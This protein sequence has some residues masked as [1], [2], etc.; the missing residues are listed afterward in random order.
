MGAGVPCARWGEAPAPGH[1]R[2]GERVLFSGRLGSQHVRVWLE[3]RP[4]GIALLSHDI[5]PALER[6]FGKDEIETFLEVDAADFSALAAA[7]GARSGDPMALLTSRFRGNS[8][9]TSELRR[10]I[11][12]HGV[13]HRFAIV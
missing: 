3:Q 10:L 11:E 7:V 9:A 2:D 4:G 6:S 8:A 1:Y 13:P 12:E 5:G